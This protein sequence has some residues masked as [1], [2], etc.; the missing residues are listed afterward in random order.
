MSA[1]ASLYISG[2]HLRFRYGIKVGAK[3]KIF[4]VLGEAVS[5]CLWGKGEG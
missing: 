4:V 5:F 2:T 1:M 3:D